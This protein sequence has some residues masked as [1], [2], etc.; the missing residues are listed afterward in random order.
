MGQALAAVLHTV[1]DP[2]CEHGD[3]DYVAHIDL[4]DG[5]H[6]MNEKATTNVGDVFSVTLQKTDG[7]PL[8]LA[9]DFVSTREVLP[10]R[11]VTG[12]LA[13]EWNRDHPDLQVRPG[14][15]IVEVNGARGIADQMMKAL[16]ESEV[17][18][19]TLVRL[20]AHGAED[21]DYTR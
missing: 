7:S 5:A 15:R 12:A 14:D 3:G 16:K 9:V 10:V 13:A 6:S 20:P 17:V 21:W 8:G 2:C 1:I 11:E 18:R 4:K 19:L